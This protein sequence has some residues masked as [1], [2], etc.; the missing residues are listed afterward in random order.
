M[1]IKGKGFMREERDSFG[2]GSKGEMGNKGE[3]NEIG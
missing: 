1:S 3:E 2:Y